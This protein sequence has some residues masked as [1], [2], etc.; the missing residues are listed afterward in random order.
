MVLNHST[1]SRGKRWIHENQGGANSRGQHIVDDFRIDV[2]RFEAEF[3][4]EQCATP[5]IDLVTYDSR[6][7]AARPDR[8]TSRAGRWFKNDVPRL[9]VEQP[10][11]KESE[12]RRSRKLLKLRLLDCA[13]SLRYQPLRQGAQHWEC[14]RI[15]AR[16]RLCLCLQQVLVHRRF[17]GVVSITRRI[18]PLCARAA[19]SPAG[20]LAEPGV[21]ERFT[22]GDTSYKFGNE[23]VHTA[24]DFFGHD[25]VLMN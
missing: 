17:E 13:I 8:Q 5:R 3:A 23:Q 18:N 11:G 16:E 7:E 1:A 25:G 10:G 6:A 12:C 22:G 20:N 15:H 4:R 24:A 21:V 2:I 14:F 19:E 9:Q